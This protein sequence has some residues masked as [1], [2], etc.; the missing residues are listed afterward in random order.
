MSTRWNP[1]ISYF[2]A[3]SSQ[4]IIP[5]IEMIYIAIILMIPDR[6]TDILNGPLVFGMI[7]DIGIIVQFFFLKKESFRAYFDFSVQ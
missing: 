2:T 1:E 4:M 5:V 6:D 7:V 3:Y